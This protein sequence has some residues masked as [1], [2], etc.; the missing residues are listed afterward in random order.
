TI[1]NIP[2][3]FFSEV[4]EKIDDWQIERFQQSF[5]DDKISFTIE[6]NH[7]EK[8]SMLSGMRAHI[9]R[10]NNSYQFIVTINSK[11]YGCPL[12]D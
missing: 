9:L 8:Y 6:T 12:D 11:N 1:C 5:Q 3:Q 4:V 7:S 2:K 10:R